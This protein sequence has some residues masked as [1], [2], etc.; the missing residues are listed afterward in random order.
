MVS[1]IRSETILNWQ[2]VYTS[3]FLNPPVRCCFMASCWRLER[4][5]SLSKPAAFHTVKSQQEGE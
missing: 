3:G 2:G 5:V 4:F 1:L